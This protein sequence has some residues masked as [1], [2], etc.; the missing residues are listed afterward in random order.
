MPAT[1]RQ[2]GIATG[3]AVFG[4]LFAT[5]LTSDIVS[6]LR[7]SPLAPHAHGIATAVSQGQAEQVFATVPPGDRHALAGVIASAFTGGLN[8][9]LVVSGV[10]ALV[11][12]VAA[13]ALI[14]TRDF[15]AYVPPADVQQP[16]DAED[17]PHR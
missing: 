11:A 16:T 15:V 8:E 3:I 4:T 9:I 2:V 5:R 17:A 10:V 12:A 14:R 13:M 6:G 7:G 1:F